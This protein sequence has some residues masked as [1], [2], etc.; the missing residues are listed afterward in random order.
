MGLRRK[1]LV[2][3]SIGVALLIWGLLKM[4]KFAKG[5]VDDK[6]R[7]DTTQIPKVFNLHVPELKSDTLKKK[8]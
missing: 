6:K 1:H 7:M 3:I 2:L 4:K 5:V 8:R